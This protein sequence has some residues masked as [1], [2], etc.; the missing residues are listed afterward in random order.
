MFIMSSIVFIS[1]TLLLSSI[2]LHQSNVISSLKLQIS[3]ADDRIYSDE[4]VKT[5]YKAE[6]ENL[7]NELLL[8]KQTKVKHKELTESC[9]DFYSLLYKDKME[10]MRL[11]NNLESNFS[12]VKKIYSSE[13]TLSDCIT[14]IKFSEKHE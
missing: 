5:R 12:K 4:A 2:L 9:R 7:T 3:H 6:I 1:V 8:E 11:F 13:T 10:I 14:H